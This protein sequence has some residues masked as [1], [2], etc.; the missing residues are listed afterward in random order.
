MRRISGCRRQR[1]SRRR[2]RSGALPGRRWS[3]PRRRRPQQ[4]SGP[5]ATS[6][7]GRIYH[8]SSHPATPQRVFHL[9]H[10][11]IAQFLQWHSFINREG[12]PTQFVKHPQAFTNP[13]P[14]FGEDN[15]LPGT[16]P[17]R[18]GRTLLSVNCVMTIT[19]ANNVSAHG[20]KSVCRHRLPENHVNAR[21]DYRPLG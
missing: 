20:P 11:P 19:A 4:R 1:P 9:R 6:A 7:S 8:F 14:R 16:P 15:N 18:D 2:P 13:S 21:T 17:A 10:D 3:R 12:N 5:M